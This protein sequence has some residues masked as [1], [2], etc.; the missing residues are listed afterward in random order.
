MYVGAGR[1]RGGA[2]TAHEGGVAP[3]RAHA[4]NV[5]V[6]VRRAQRLG[7][8]DLAPVAR[9]QRLAEAAET[10]AEPGPG[11]LLR[12]ALAALSA[13]HHSTGWAT[14]LAHSPWPATGAALPGRWG[15]HHLPKPQSWTISIPQPS[16]RALT[17][18]LEI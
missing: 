13:G 16:L 11:T 7:A 8:V 18:V 15:E 4:A 2:L 14:I 5:G 9:A 17:K 1:G 6:Q 10:E 3:A 12:H